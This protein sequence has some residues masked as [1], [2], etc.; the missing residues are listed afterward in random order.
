M[1]HTILLEGSSSGAESPQQTPHS[2]F[3]TFSPHILSSR[4][5][6]PQIYIHTEKAVAPAL[7]VTEKLGIGREC[8]GLVR[9]GGEKK[10]DKKE[11]ELGHRASMAGAPRGVM[12]KRGKE[13]RQ[14]KTK[15]K[16]KLREQEN[17][18]SEPQLSA[19]LTHTL[20]NRKQC[21]PS[22]SPPCPRASPPPPLVSPLR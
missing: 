18:L 1:L 19:R 21:P 14:D 8:G 13:N 10:T 6:T 15:R 2:G 16:G 9:E 3:F 17:Q 11:E 7:P 20:C 12:M 22:P 4:R 5:R